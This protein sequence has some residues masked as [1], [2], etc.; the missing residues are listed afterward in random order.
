MAR[1]AAR[2]AQGKP[3]PEIVGRVREHGL[4]YLGENAL[5]DLYDQ[6]RRVEEQ[7]REGILIEAGCALGGSAIV[8]AAAKNNDR[9]LAV[10]DVFGMIPAPSDQD[11]EDVHERYRQIVRGESKGIDGATYY[12]YEEDLLSKVCGNFAAKGYPIEEHRV[13]LIKGLFQDTL[14]VEEPVA[15]AHIDGDWY[16]SVKIC[17][18]RIEP[19]LVSGGVLIIDDYDCWSGCRRA[20]NEYFAYKSA[21]YKFVQRSRLH[22][23]RSVDSRA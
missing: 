13:Q 22:I 7:P 8:M 18:E 14:R 4:T 5:F 21:Q 1:R 17:L 15:L 9:P 12:G 3:V 19:H 16:E 11:S 23:I 20:V 6:V 10:Y 2:R